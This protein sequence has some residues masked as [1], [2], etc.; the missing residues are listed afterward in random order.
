MRPFVLDRDR[1]D[2]RHARRFTAR[3]VRQRTPARSDVTYTPDA[4]YNG[5]DSFTFKV[6]DGA[7]DSADATVTITVNGVNDPP[8]AVNDSYNVAEDT[9]LTVAVPGV[10]ANDTDVDGDSLTAV[11]VAS[12]AHGTLTLNADGSFSYT[13]AANY[14]GADSF[15]YKANDGAA[16]S[17]VATV[18]LAISAVNDAPANTVPGDAQTVNEDIDLVFSTASS[19]ALSVADVDAAPST[20]QVTVSALNGAITP[21]TGSG[22]TVGGSGSASATIA[23]TLTQVNAA[24]NGLKYRGN[25]NWN[26]TCGQEH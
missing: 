15:T 12:P 25:A 24:L 20:I 6:N 19:N 9:Q 23:G 14:N 3:T 21:A 1:T 7:S 17:N 22:A 11:L 2:S 5:T 26:S 10:L 4:N 18:S 13:P 8:V 16:D